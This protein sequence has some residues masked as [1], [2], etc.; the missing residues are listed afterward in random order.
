MAPSTSP[1]ASAVAGLAAAARPPSRRC[2]LVGAE[3]QARGQQ[4]RRPGHP[5]LVRA[6]QAADRA[7]RASSPA[8]TSSCTPAG[9]GGTLTNKLVLTQ[10]D[11]TGD[12]AFGVD[13]TFAT[14]ALDADVFAPYD[15]PLPAGRRA[16]TSCPATTTASRRSTT[17]TSASTSTPPGSP[18]TTSP[19]R[20]RSTTWSK[21]AY[22]GLLAVPGATTSSTGLAFLLGTIGKYG[23][24]GRTYW[25][26]LVANGATITDGWSQ[27]YETDFTQ[28]GGHGRLPDRRLLRLLA[29]VHRPEGREHLD[30][31]GAARHLLPPGRVRRRA[32]RRRRTSKGAKAFVDFLLS[33]AVQRAL[34][35][36]MYVFPVRQR[37]AAARAPGRG[38]PSSRST[39]H[40]QPRRHHRPPRR[41]A[42]RS[43]ATS[44]ADDPP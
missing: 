36:A 35:D 11:P 1:R 5:R 14:R 24:G 42:A 29:G 6:A 20:A 34:P 26:A 43:G 30:H 28:G 18:T 15:V 9:D 2:S 22:D 19:R 3:R 38:S 10:G 39:R 16:A 4:G 33:P 8:T 27:A 40:G 31:Q 25:Q 12:V 21:P 23:D 37:D 41:V 32:R 7:V 17:A 44:S 13:N